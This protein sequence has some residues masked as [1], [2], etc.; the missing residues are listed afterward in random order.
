[1]PDKKHILFMSSWYPHDGKPFLGNFV[2]RQAELLS[3]SFKVTVVFTVSSEHHNTCSLKSSSTGNLTEIIIYHPPGKSLISKSKIQKKALNLG[4][5]KLERV[6]LLFTQVILPRGWQFL[7]VHKKF[8]CPWIHLEQG[9]YFRKEKRDQWNVFEKL[10]IRKSCKKISRLLAA[11][12]F[13]KTD[14][15]QV[16]SNRSINVVPNHVDTT[17]FQPG[18]FTGTDK[19]KFLHVSTLDENTKN[20]LGM[21]EACSQLKS[22]IGELFEFLIISDEPT[23]KWKK[24]VSENDLQ[25]VV[26]FD[27][28]KEWHELP[29]YYQQADAFVLNSI[30][31]TF[32]IVLA[33]AW[34]CGTPTIT[35]PVGIGFDLPEFL[36]YNAAINNSTSLK[37]AMLKFIQNKSNF[38]RDEIRAHGMNFSSEIVLEQLTSTIREHIG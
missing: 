3:Q 15:K 24:Y 6:D 37:N 11:S 34:A 33:E 29:S 20:P 1:M 9:S 26:K 16:F 35:T 10:I 31:E 32:S 14:L 7:A 28:P 36:G 12:Q 19:V 8:N 2:Q 38:N 18:N 5:Q 21:L 17:L 4:L 23:E 27:G 25:N 22:E 13:L 30:Y